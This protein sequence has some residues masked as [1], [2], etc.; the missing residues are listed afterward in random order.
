MPER[1]KGFMV[2]K[3]GKDQIETVVEERPVREL[4]D[5]EV[6]IRVEFSSVNYKDAM[7]ATG[8]PGITKK[9]PHIPG[10]DSVGTVEE[11]S[12]SRFSR[13]DEVIM[14]GHGLGVERW[15]GWAEY[16]RVPAEW[17]VPLPDG[18]TSREA[19][20]L[21]TA[22]FTAAQCVQAIQL[23]GITPERGEV[24]VTGATGGVGSIAVMLLAKQGYPVVAVTG[25]ES[26]RDW[27][28]ELG[29]TRVIDRS[30]ASSDT[31][32]PLLKT[33][34][35]GAVDTV[36]GNTL[37]TLV[38]SMEHRGCVAACGVVGG[39]ELPLTVYPFILRGVTLAGIDSAWCPDD[40]RAEIWQRLATDWKLDGLDRLA[41]ET[42]LS[43]VG[44]VVQ[45]MM[46]GEN[47]GRVLVR[48][49]A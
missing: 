29:A 46:Q 7:A 38:R 31:D 8:H 12:S 15:G 5:G 21:G 22:G 3:T 28:T 25:K 48:P 17:V 37:T 6:L 16:V 32:R 2:C 18:M 1:F 14:T 9:F 43:G 47:V 26:R 42:D 44:D 40:L 11:S 33:Q 20:T 45:R 34:W 13:G 30:D 10:I 41:S 4:P 36:G 24:V 35:A 27:L 39:P 19:M 49:S 23:Q